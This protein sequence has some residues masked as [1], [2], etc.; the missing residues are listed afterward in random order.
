MNS[1]EGKESVSTLFHRHSKHFL[2]FQLDRK[3]LGADLVLLCISR[4]AC[5]STWLQTTCGNRSCGFSCEVGCS[6][7]PV[8]EG[9]MG[10]EGEQ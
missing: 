2:S 7:G 3:S 4:R 1:F 10:R 5:H 6:L 8:G 9:W